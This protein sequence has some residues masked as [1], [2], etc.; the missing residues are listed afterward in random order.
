MRAARRQ[1]LDALTRQ[2]MKPSVRRIISGAFT[3][4]IICALVGLDAKGQQKSITLPDDN[5][6]AQLKGGRNVELARNNCSSCHSTDYIVR[7][8]GSDAK[9]WEAEVIKMI[10]VYGAP[11]SE[12]DAKAIVDYLATSYGPEP[13]HTPVVE[14]ASTGKKNKKP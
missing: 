8:P 3:A 12:A 11:I 7:Q 10:K 9:K 5:P 6:M 14:P 2:A 13:N 1:Q 4:T